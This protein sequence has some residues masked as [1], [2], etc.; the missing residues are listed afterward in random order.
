MSTTIGDFVVRLVMQDE[1]FDRGA[2][3][4]QKTLAGLGEDFSRFAD[5]LGG[6]FVTAV[7]AATAAMGAFIASSVEV[8]AGFE[9]SI[10]KVGVLAGGVT[11]AK[12]A[13][14]ALS[15]EARRLGAT[16]AYSAQEAADAMQ[17]LAS[18]GL[19]TNEII[20]ATNSALYLA[21]ASGSDLESST[22]ILVSTM[23][24]FGLA[25]TEAGRI[26]DVFSTAMNVST[27]DMTSLT[28]AMKYAGTVGRAFGYSLEQTTA[29]VALFKDLGLEGSKAGTAFRNALSQAT[30]V[31]KKGEEALARYGLTVADINPE[32][33]SFSEL[34]TRIGQAGM[35]TT[36]LIAI[37]GTEAA[38]SISVVSQA[39]A[40]GTT[41]FDE[42][43][44]AFEASGGSTKQVYEAM[45][46]TVKNRFD[47]VSSAAE[48]LQLV[49]F[50]TYGPPLRDLLDEVSRL[51]AYVA[52]SFTSASGEIGGGFAEQV[53]SLID[54]LQQNRQ[55]IALGFQSF[56]QTTVSLGAA[57]VRLLPVLDDLLVLMGSVFLANRVRLFV[58]A[59]VSAVGAMT[60]LAG[61][62]ATV[63]TVLRTLYASLVAMSG[64]TLALVAAVGTLVVAIGSYVLASNSAEAA[65]ER[66][67]AAE[68]TLAKEA[69]DRAAGE[70]ARAADL[71][72]AQARRLGAYALEL[73]QRGE[74][75]N[76]IDGQLSR[77][78]A[79]SEAQIAEGL[80]SGALF[81]TM[82]NGNRVVLD[83]ATLLELAT[84]GA[85][86]YE[87]ALSGM[88]AAQAANIAE[89]RAAEQRL[90]EIEEAQ[91]QY[92]RMTREG[93]GVTSFFTSILGKYGSS[94]EEVQARTAA[95]AKAA[96]D[97]RAK[98]KTFANEALL[99]EQALQ[100]K[101][102]ASGEASTGIRK[103]SNETKKAGKSSDDYASK[104]RAA[105]EARLSLSRRITEELTKASGDETAVILADLRKREE[106]VRRVYEA[107]IAL[108]KKKKGDVTRLNASLEADL[109]SIRS[110]AQAKQRAETTRLVDEIENEFR[111]LRQTDEEEAAV[112]ASDR[113]DL[114]AETFS[115]EAA[116][117][118]EGSEGRLAVNRRF[119]AALAL[120]EANEQEKRAEQQREADK[121][122]EDALRSLR[123]DNATA[124]ERIE[125][126][127]QKAITEYARAAYALREQIA[128]EYDRRV[129]A[130]RARISSEI[131]ILTGR[132]TEEIA[133]LE[134]EAAATGSKRRRERLRSEAETLRR[135]DALEREQAAKLVEYAD[136]TDAEKAEIVASYSRK[137]SDVREEAAAEER[138][139]A[140]ETLAEIGRAAVATVSTVASAISSV[141]GSAVSGLSSLFS[142]LTGGLTLSLTDVASSVLDEIDEAREELETQLKEGAITPEEYEAGLSALDPT[143]AARDFVDGLLSE[144][145]TFA[146]TLAA[147]AP[148]FIAALVEGLPVLVDALVAAI[149]EIVGGLASG[150][151][152]LVAV[153]VDAVPAF[154]QAIVDAIPLVVDALVSLLVDGL[155]ALLDGL[156]PV[157]SNLIGAIVEAVPVIVEAIVDALPSVV[158]FITQAVSDVLAALPEIVSSLLAAVPQIV[159]TLLAGISDLV[160]AVFDAIPGIIGAVIEN[161]P[162]IVEALVRGVLGLVEKVVAALPSLIAGIVA[163]LPDL[164]EALLLLVT[165][166]VVAILEAIPTIIEGF[167]LALPE[168]ITSVIRAIPRIIVSLVDA[169]P[170]LLVAI[171]GGLIDL[172]PTLLAAIIKALPEIIVALVGG[173]VEAVPALIEALLL[174]LPVA[175]AVAIGEA[176]LD[177]LRSLVQFFKDVINEIVS[178]GMDETATFGDTPGAVK[179]GAEGML[180]R[181]APGDFVVAA[182]KPMDL[183]RQALEATGGDVGGA[184]GG[185]PPSA[186][187]VAAARAV[188]S[189]PID[190]AIM[191]EGRLL[192]A[193]QVTALDR[194]HAPRL[195]HRLRR[196]SGVKVGVDRGRFNPYTSS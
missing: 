111:R 150:L 135:I 37:F 175:L 193:V 181:F 1:D 115:R 141:V 32:Q 35:T 172:I 39:F 180:A 83:Q 60:S 146:T 96:E 192:D 156:G 92:A 71:E 82:I 107:E 61:A 161:L 52:T 16:T 196:A 8:G 78:A 6:V 109:A 160:L 112:A 66:Q 133:A 97:A 149:P 10:T 121:R 95:Y 34:M 110:I 173:L 184:M 72:A 50:D 113:I 147:A 88:Q 15:G 116:L 189:P 187:P 178:L 128:A 17:S 124:I 12:T 117:Y 67:R 65:A 151:P 59:V 145:A 170:D 100:K 188:A 11:D 120:L 20:A 171:V 129:L 182:Q 186:P 42:Y 21:G 179:A 140:K 101:A 22:G 40:D 73:Q 36:D 70:A 99:A 48:E 167:L 139:R 26:S 75:T 164:V 190:I 168:L 45:T 158:S 106:E 103:E 136:A 44:T 185:A 134:D 159:T 130:E 64:G 33:Q 57:L 63:G 19:K 85:T 93:I 30:S 155:P 127:K 105:T 69:A 163:L 29:A 142:T 108:V 87:D 38:G 4:A 14:T 174:D 53:K 98:T 137:V 119:L 18:A 31:S 28:E 46:D 176:V 54:Y 132:E 191:A 84:T 5:T 183:L 55:S 177:G 114:L 122:A 91:K 157:V 81:E 125:A 47:E 153:L 165:D 143:Q 68:E 58:S 51:I 144:A 86:G 77:L 23:S 131:L 79:L 166:L 9:A 126:E 49:L 154:V 195:E 27:L 76:T 194:G 118:E 41:K 56:V 80:A 94:L 169:L 102:V 62:G 138:A 74:L 152:A 123:S 148:G 104:L 13:I 43:V 3:N 24:Q 90:A 162:S 7:G 2:K 25:A 89:M